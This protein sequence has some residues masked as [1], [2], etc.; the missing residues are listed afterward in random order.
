MDDCYDC[1]SEGEN[2]NS[3]FIESYHCIHDYLRLEFVLFV[4]LLYLAVY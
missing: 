3:D 4:F 2:Y 1:W